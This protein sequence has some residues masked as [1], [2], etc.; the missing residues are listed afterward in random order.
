MTHVESAFPWLLGPLSYTLL[1]QWA[2]SQN[3]HS[4]ALQLVWKRP[5]PLAATLVSWGGP[6]AQLDG[7][8]IW[9]LRKLESKI[10]SYLAL[11]ALPLCL[12][13]SEGLTQVLLILNSPPQQAALSGCG[14]HI[15]TDDWIDVGQLGQ[16]VLEIISELDLKSNENVVALLGSWGRQSPRCRMGSHRAFRTGLAFVLAPQ[17]HLPTQSSHC[18]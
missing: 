6:L 5:L 7:Y 1:S 15:N 16:Y 13:G 12:P 18:N 10:T 8:L 11:P 3:P 17:R 14:K 9:K 2:W 4:T